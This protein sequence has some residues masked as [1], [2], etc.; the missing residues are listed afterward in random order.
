MAAAGV[1]L[2]SELVVAGNILVAAGTLMAAEY[3][4]GS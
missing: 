3:L 2:V 4:D 1:I